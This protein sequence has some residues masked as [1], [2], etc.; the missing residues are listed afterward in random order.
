MSDIMANSFSAHL[1]ASAHRQ[2][3]LPRSQ[4]KVND[5]TVCS[6]PSFLILSTIY[7]YYKYDCDKK[8]FWRVTVYSKEVLRQGKRRKKEARDQ[9]RKQTASSLKRRACRAH[10]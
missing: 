7:F 5:P 6:A 9:Q 1:S 2:S 3:I 8:S 4:P 10:C